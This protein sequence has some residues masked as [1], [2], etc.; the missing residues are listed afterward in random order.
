MQILLAWRGNKW[1]VSRNVVE[2]GSYPYRAH[3]LDMVR[4]LAE[5]ARTLGLDCYLLVRERNGV[6]DERPCPSPP[7]RLGAPGGRRSRPPGL[8]R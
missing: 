4:R 8:T 5:E 2:V 6:W 7:R 1:V 3:A